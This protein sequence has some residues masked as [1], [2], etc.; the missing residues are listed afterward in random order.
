MQIG[1]SVQFGSQH[2]FDRIPVDQTMDDIVNP[3]TQTAEA[4]K[5]FGLK[6]PA[7]ER[8]YLTSE[9]YSVYLKQVR[10][11]MGRGMTHLSHPDRH[12]LKIISD[13]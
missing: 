11:M 12:M 7:V 8:Y 2:P 3:D 4:T 10:K 13:E 1:F 6:R 5:G 9:Y